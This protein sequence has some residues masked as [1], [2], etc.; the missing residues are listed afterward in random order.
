MSKRILIGAALALAAGLAVATSA[1]ADVHVAD[2]EDQVFD[3]AMLP[4]TYNTIANNWNEQG[5]HFEGGQFYFVP[6][7]N[8]LALPAVHNSTFLEGAI[9]TAVISRAYGGLFDLLSLDLALGSWNLGS[10]D[11]VVITG[12]GA[13][14]PTCQAT[15]QVDDRAF[16]HFDLTG[17]TG[18]TSF[19]VGMPQYRDGN[20]DLQWDTG[21]LAFDNITFQT[22]G[23]IPEPAEWLL[24]LGGLTA[25]GV[26][27]RRAR[28]LAVVEA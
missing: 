17:F 3:P 24:L 1:V 10:L 18:L 16:T 27:L 7:V 9:E 20:G 11:T 6:A 28:Q 5:L 26:M 23:G 8:D 15:V 12:Q 19:T 25:C 14:A 2:F 13:C 21:Y 22:K 4:Y